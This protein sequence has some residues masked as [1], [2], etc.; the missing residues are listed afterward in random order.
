MSYLAIIIFKNLIY[1][2][3]ETN[4]NDVPTSK[5]EEIANS[6]NRQDYTPVADSP[7]KLGPPKQ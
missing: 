3:N 4:P 5:Q 1:A 7:S 6:A 2:N